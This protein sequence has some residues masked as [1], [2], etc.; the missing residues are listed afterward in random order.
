MDMKNQ[1]AVVTGATRGIGQAIL[2]CFVELGAQVIATGTSVQKGQDG[3]VFWHPLNL[4]EDGSVQEFCD[5]LSKQERIDA[6]VNNAGINIIQPLEEIPLENYEK[7]LKVNLTGPFRLTQAVA[8]KMRTQR[9]GRI[10]NVSSIWGV[11]GKEMRHSYAS[12]KT[13][14]IGLTRTSALDLASDQVLVNAL[15]PGFTLTEL[16]RK[17]LSDEEMERLSSQV[18]MRRFAEVEEMA[19]TAA[20]LCSSWNSYI[21][22]QAVTADGGFTIC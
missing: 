22:G 2:E 11:I 16:T 10:L 13:G 19:R 15:C 18:P 1:V 4:A 14:L 7:V 20:F 3:Q 17:S 21:T 5:Y 8:P 6:L 9:Y 12:S